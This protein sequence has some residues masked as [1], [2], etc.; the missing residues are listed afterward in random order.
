MDR[1]RLFRV[2]GEKY[3][4]R[5]ELY[6]YL[7]LGVN[8]DEIWSTVLEQRRAKAIT[9]PLTNANGVPYWYTLTDRMIIASENI[10]NELYECDYSDKLLSS[11]MTIREIF[12]TGYLEGSQISA[13]EAVSFLQ[14]GE[15]AL[16][17]EELMILNNR[18]A[19]SF[20]A[21]NIYRPLNRDYLQ[22]LAQILTNGLDN[23]G[24]ELRT[25]DSVDIYFMQGESYVLPSAARLNGCINEITTFL[26]DMSV[27]PLIKAAVAQAWA[28]VV[29]PF[30]DGN[31]RLGRLLSEIILIRSGYTFFGEESISAVIAKSGFKYFDAIAKIVRGANGNDLTYFLDYYLS[32]LSDFV[33]EIRDKRKKKDT[34]SIEAEREMARSSLAPGNNGKLNISE[35]VLE[36]VDDTIEDIDTDAI[37]KVIDQEQKKKVSNSKK[38]FLGV[39]RSFLLT[40]KHRFTSKD[41][42]S[43]AN[44]EIST[45]SIGNFMQSLVIMGIVDRYYASHHFYTYF[46]TQAI[47]SEYTESTSGNSIVKEE[48]FNAILRTI[49]D[50][51]TTEKGKWVAEQFLKYLHSGKNFFTKE[52]IQQSGGISNYE[53][54]SII[55]CYCDKGI[56]EKKEDKYYFCIEDMLSES[57]YSDDIINLIE[58]LINSDKSSKKDKRIGS[59]IQSCLGKG[60]ITTEYYEKIGEITKMSTD[61]A[62]AKQLGLVEP[63]PDG[64]YR[65]NNE[66]NTS[67]NDI[68][69]YTKNVLS[70]MYKIF[71][72]GIFSAEMVIAEL[73][74]SHS[75]TNATL[76]KLMWLKVLNCMIGEDKR[77]TYQF[78]ITPEDHPECFVAAA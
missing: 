15:E 65:I 27:H 49:T 25:E 14:R 3:I 43:A 45:R 74:Y 77:Y 5:N 55:R 69:N 26:A 11:V 66:L 6:G 54:R 10:V 52:E 50:G 31:E 4:A 78:M 1:E 22:V 30:P 8:A 47:S 48:T 33:D 62:F 21:E 53:F 35:A 59:V 56:I 64:N 44:G 13:Q 20:A 39:I 68:E 29:R 37:L 67:F 18:Q 76:H 40:G 58:E 16:D 73:K 2:I 72:D 46:F 63:L 41:I 51:H 24:G 32:V 23:G 36:E 19:G 9:L 28:M 42:E 38:V 12:F 17:A 60:V 70:E 57:Q 34:E 61:M 71:G 75:H 7:P